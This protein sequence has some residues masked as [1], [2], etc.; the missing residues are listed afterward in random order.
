MASDVGAAEIWHMATDCR[1][2]FVD[3]VATPS[4]GEQL[5]LRSAQGE[6]N[7]WCTSIKATKPTTDKSS[8][9]YRL[10]KDKWKDVRD[11]IRDLLRSLSGALRQC[12]DLADGKLLFI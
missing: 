12:R 6:F 10:R 4:L 1:T 2:T 7:L 3:C 9:D 8:L 5:W 11:D